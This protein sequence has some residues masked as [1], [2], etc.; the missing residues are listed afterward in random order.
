MCSR[1]QTLGHPVGYFYFFQMKL[2]RN[3]PK[4]PRT[5]L[6]SVP[7]FPDLP[8]NDRALCLFISTLPRSERTFRIACN[9]FP[10]SIQFHCRLRYG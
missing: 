6:C 10:L 3:S 7:L 2:E 9:H 8:R 1:S 5:L 4:C